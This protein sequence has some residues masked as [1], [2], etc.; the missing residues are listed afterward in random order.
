V[1]Y[2]LEKTTLWQHMQQLQAVYAGNQHDS[3]FMTDHK[4]V[5]V[6][7]FKF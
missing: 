2:K 3:E 5:L 6:F 4:R 7:M 1:Y